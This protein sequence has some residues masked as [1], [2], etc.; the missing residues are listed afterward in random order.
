[1]TGAL[2]LEID[3]SSYYHPRYLQSRIAN[4]GKAMVE[5]QAANKTNGGIWSAHK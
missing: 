1:V 5:C 2:K 3:H 4:L